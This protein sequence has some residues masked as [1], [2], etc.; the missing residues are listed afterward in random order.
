M[1][2]IR[3]SVR[4]KGNVVLDLN[5]TALLFCVVEGNLEIRK[6]NAT[7]TTTDVFGSMKVIG[8][9]A[10]LVQNRIQGEWTI[11][12]SEHLCDGN[13]SFKDKDSD[14][15]VDEGEIASTLSCE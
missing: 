11:E 9:N 2:L 14:L 12:G 15:I 4:I 10:V 3:P 13:S 7:V 1:G 8:N 6:N 5:N